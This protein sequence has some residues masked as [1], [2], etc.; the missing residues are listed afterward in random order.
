MYPVPALGEEP[1]LVDADQAAQP[2]HRDECQQ[3]TQRHVA[4]HE[5]A[6]GSGLNP[7]EQGDHR[8]GPQQ[9]AEEGQ[10]QPAQFGLAP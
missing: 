6:Q 4:Q 3:K 1:Y 5:G 7:E 10:C 8:C 9:F 2:E